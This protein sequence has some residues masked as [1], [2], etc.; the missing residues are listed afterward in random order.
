MTAITYGPFKT[1]TDPGGIPYGGKER[2]GSR[3]FP[4][5]SVDYR[6]CW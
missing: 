1:G 6:G 5:G 2:D 4:E 3:Y